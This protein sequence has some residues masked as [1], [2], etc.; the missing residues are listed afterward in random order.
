[1][2]LVVDENLEV[3]FEKFN[4]L[5]DELKEERNA[6]EKIQNDFK[7]LKAQLD[8][9][10]KA[11]IEFQ[12]EVRGALRQFVAAEQGVNRAITNSCNEQARM[13][14][15]NREGFEDTQQM[16]L[17]KGEDVIEEVQYLSAAVNKLQTLLICKDDQIQ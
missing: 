1:M 13:R 2:V 11:D 14:K 15:K 8:K 5:E 4:K 16:V 3:F 7:N 9:K 6:K 17:L 12:E 10:E